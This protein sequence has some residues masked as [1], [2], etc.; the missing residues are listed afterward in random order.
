MAEYLSKVSNTVINLF[1]IMGLVIGLAE[2]QQLNF[3]D[4]DSLHMEMDL[5]RNKPGPRAK[6]QLHYF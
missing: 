4:P 5:V 1:G 6:F 2:I 3:K